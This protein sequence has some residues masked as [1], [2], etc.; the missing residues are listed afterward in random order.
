MSLKLVPS[1]NNKAHDILIV[2]DE[3]DICELIS[4]VLQDEGFMTRYANSGQQALDAIAEKIPSLVIQDIWLND[5]EYDGVKILEKLTHEYPGLPVIMM[6]GHGTIETAVNAIRIGAYDF[7]EKPFKSDRL[8]LMIRRA[9]EAYEMAKENQELKE[10]LGEVDEL[11]GNSA[12]TKQLRLDIERV[13]LTNSRVL[14]SGPSGSGKELIARHI[15]EQSHRK[16]GPFITINCGTLNSDTFEKELFGV[17][18]KQDK[19]GLKIG[20]FEK[21]NR[22]TILLDEVA[23]LPREVQAKLVRVIHEMAIERVGGT[24]KIKIDMR[25]IATTTQD[26]E[27]LVEQ[28]KFR[29]DLYYRLNVVALKAHGLGDRREDIVNLVNYFSQKLARQLG[30]A[31][32]QFD[33]KSLLSLKGHDWPGNARQLKNVIEHALILY[34]QTNEEVLI[35]TEMLPLNFSGKAFIS[36]SQENLAT[37][38]NILQLPLREARESFE[39]DYLIAQVRRFSGNI[40]HTASFVGMERSALHRKLRNLDVKREE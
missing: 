14:L 33:E 37:N 39:R 32:C 3:Q 1:L 40:S 12:V 29:E 38:S 18:S 31:P 4:D 30:K 36:E 24:R 34:G 16:N 5:T 2:D 35:T 25:I 20:L 11:V 22:G 13:A 6:S 9:I 15:H 28:K 27:K 10:M 26:I 21:A 17:E 7:V 19:L 8:L 23:D